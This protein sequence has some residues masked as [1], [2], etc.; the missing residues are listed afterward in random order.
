MAK[1]TFQQ[2]MRDAI[3]SLPQDMKAVLRIV[4]DP[5]LEEALR[6]E[7]AGALLHVLS[8]HNAIPGMRGTLALADDAIMLRLMLERLDAA[9]PEQMAARRDH[10]PELFEPLDAQMEAVRA[11]LGERMRVL[12]AQAATL[13]E[14]THQGHAANDCARDEEEAT[15]LY[16]AVH[17]AIIAEL[18]LD[19]DEV[20]RAL[21]GC[22]RILPALEQ[23]MAP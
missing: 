14:I 20:E 5:D 4:E 19:E 12:E 1:E 21:K 3:M 6:A 17:E 18:D 15:W 8:A 11:Y 16:D 2:A 13:S 9:A 10:D 23:R 22:D 7:A